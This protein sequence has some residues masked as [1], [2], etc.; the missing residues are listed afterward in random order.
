MSVSRSEHYPE[1]GERLRLEGAAATGYLLNLMRYGD[2]GFDAARLSADAVAA[3]RGDRRA[4]L[5]LFGIVR[6]RLPA[7]RRRAGSGRRPSGRRLQRRSR[8]RSP[9]RDG[10]HPHRPAPSRAIGLSGVAAAPRQDLGKAGADDPASRATL[11]RSPWSVAMAYGIV[12]LYS[13]VG[14]PGTSAPADMPAAAPAPVAAGGRSAL[15]AAVGRCRLSGS[16]PFGSWRG[17]A[18]DSPVQLEGGSHEPERRQGAGRGVAPEPAEPAPAP[19]GAARAAAAD[20]RGGAGAAEARPLI[21]LPDGTVIAGNMRLAAVQGLGWTHVPAVFAELDDV[22]AALW[23]FLDNRSF[24]EDDDDLV[25]ELL[26]ELDARGADLDLTGFERSE[27]EALLRRLL[28]RDRDPDAVPPLPEGVPDSKPGELYELGPHRL[29]CGDATDPAA[30]ELLLAG[31]RPKLCVTDPPFGI[32]YDP[33]WRQQAAAEG[34]L[35]YAARRVG[36]VMNDD[37]ADWGETWALLPSDVLYCFHAGL[38]AAAVAAGIEAAGFELRAQIIWSKPHFPISRGHYAWTHE[39]VWYAVRRGASAGW[40]GDRRQT[41]VWE[42]PLDPNVDGGHSTQ[43][44]VE[45]FARAVGNHA[46][47]VL[48]PFAGTGSSMV[49]AALHGRRSFLLEVEPAWCDVIRGRWE[50]FNGGR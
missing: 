24:G 17:L 13:L 32:S 9:G 20:N 2:R 48:D 31:E 6:R 4:L 26:A 47:D 37:R 30:V 42:V 41:T 18:C 46:G 39:P 14:S 5:R 7:V 28:V 36:P 15:S 40:V 3:Q 49:S 8:A 50:A 35:A 34:H 25:A 19:A 10:P 23:M 21:A 12:V 38:Q 16:A 22:R 44:P 29:L 33:G 11:T 45:L 43:K 27:T 1:C